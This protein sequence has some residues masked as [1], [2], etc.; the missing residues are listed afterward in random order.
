MHV[1]VCTV[2]RAKVLGSKKILSFPIVNTFPNW[3]NQM[4]LLCLSFSTTLRLWPYSTG[5]L[6]HQAFLPPCGSVA[7]QYR[8]SGTPS[9]STTLRLS[10]LT[11]PV[12][13]YTKLFYH[14]C[15]SGLTV[16]VVR[17]TGTPSFSTT[18]C[19]CGLTVPV[20]RYTKLFY[21]PACP[22]AVALQ[23][24]WSGTSSSVVAIHWYYSRK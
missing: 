20:V 11:I 24:R 19:G 5:G 10:G 8:W 16:P 15:G 22:V 13:R 17:Y 12:V 1:P 21:H 23:Y 2:Y 18:P 14:P 7:L 6:V 3:W 9:F 4:L